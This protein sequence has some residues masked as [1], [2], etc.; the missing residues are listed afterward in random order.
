[1]HLSA[2]TGDGVVP[3]AG[4]T[5]KVNDGTGQETIARASERMVSC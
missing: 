1:M 2:P 5:A 4:R 3:G